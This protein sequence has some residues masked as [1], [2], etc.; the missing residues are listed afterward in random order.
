MIICDHNLDEKIFIVAEIGNNHEGNFQTALELIDAAS[1]TGVNAIK[2][3]TCIPEKFYACSEPTRIET[4]KK[5]QLTSDNLKKIKT[6]ANS[7]GLIFFSTP[8][9]LESA[10]F[11]NPL[12]NLFKISSG[13]N[14]FWPL[15]KEV[16]SYKKPTIISTGTSGFT[17]LDKIY[18][19][20]ERINQLNNLIFLHCVSSYPVPTDQANLLMIKKLAKKYKNIKVGYSDHTIGIEAATCA[21]GLGA[22]II[23]KH[24]TLDKNY[25]NFRDHQLSAEP[26]EMKL[27]VERIR[28]VEDLIKPDMPD[29]QLCEKTNLTLIRRSMAASRNIDKGNKLALED[30]MYVRPGS[31][32]SEDMERKVVGKITSKSISKGEL[33]S[34]DNIISL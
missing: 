27:L 25:S 24:F 29:V 34:K 30:I 18:N 21:A 13:D 1:S 16:A 5:F 26:M 9:D 10:K 2:F 32:L 23:E 17:E 7:K 12:Q 20:Y 14:T 19:Y 33:F 8:L 22:R 6:F 31:G 11:L 4:Y 3:Q 28:E 15:I